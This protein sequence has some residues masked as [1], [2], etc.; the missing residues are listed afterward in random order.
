VAIKYL[1]IQ[2][3]FIGDVILATAL[4]EKIHSTYPDAEIDFLIKKGNE[5]IL[6]GHPL[7]KRVLL[8]DKKSKINSLRLLI[9]E[10]RKNRY[11][12]VVNVHRHFSSGLLTALSGAKERIGFKSN[13]LSFFYSK[14]IEHYWEQHEV[15]RNQKLIAYLSD[16]KAALPKLY[17]SESDWEFV[18]ENYKGAYIT[19]SPASIWPTKSLPLERWAVLINALPADKKVYLMGSASDTPSCESLKA[20]CKSQSVEILAGKLSFLKDAALM[21]NAE[22]NYV[23]DSGPLHI[24]SAMNAPVTAVFCSTSTKYGFGPL[25]EQSII[26]ETREKLSCRPCGA[27]GHKKCPKGHFK[28]ANVSFD[29]LRPIK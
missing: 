1:I 6:E 19:I 25:S 4:I 28:C 17:P 14:K 5:K 23:L 21:A 29:N 7:L 27:H 8:F 2:T 15:E 13:P 20:L 16:D 9:T 10:I 18:S 22:M 12:I 3:A 24:C 11:D 26:I